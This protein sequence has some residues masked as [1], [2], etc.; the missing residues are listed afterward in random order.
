MFDQAF[1][2]PKR[3]VIYMSDKVLAGQAPVMKA[4][5]FSNITGVLHLLRSVLFAVM[6]FS[7]RAQ[8]AEIAADAAASSTSATLESIGPNQ[9][10]WI[11]AAT[12]NGLTAAKTD[13]DDP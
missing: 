6:A 10:V 5:R 7:T 9:K 8:E 1:F 2:T 13:K 12:P 4:G 11:K 3:S